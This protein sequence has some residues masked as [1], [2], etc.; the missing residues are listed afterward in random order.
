MTQYNSNKFP[1]NFM[2]F[3]VVGFIPLT[4]DAGVSI[5]DL[6]KVYEK[7]DKGQVIES[8]PGDVQ[9]PNSYMNMPYP[10]DDI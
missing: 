7:K 5:A 6:F 4:P 3:A 2:P 8:L 10:E 9:I 1:A